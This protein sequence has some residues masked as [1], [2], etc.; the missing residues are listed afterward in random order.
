[1]LTDNVVY[2]SISQPFQIYFVMIAFWELFVI[3][4]YIADNAAFW[5]FW[6]GLLF[7]TGIN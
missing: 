1:M 6:D 3:I 7:D 5:S 2:G 4:A